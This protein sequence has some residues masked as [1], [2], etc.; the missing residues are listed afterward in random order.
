MR[1]TFTATLPYRLYHNVYEMIK[2]MRYLRKPK[3]LG[4]VI[5]VGE[6]GRFTAVWYLVCEVVE[7]SISQHISKI[8]QKYLIG[9]KLGVPGIKAGCFCLPPTSPARITDGLAENLLY[10]FFSNL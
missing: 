9:L 4:F 7:E 8:L 2:D 3:R 1:K 5:S 6:C 10:H